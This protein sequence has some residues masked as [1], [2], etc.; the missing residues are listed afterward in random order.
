VTSGG[1]EFMTA[2]EWL[3]QV[4]RRLVMLLRG[5][6]FDADLEEEM[7]LHR[8]LR[9]QEQ[10]ERGLSLQETHYAAQRRFGND[11]LLREESR[12]MWEWNLF[13]NLLRDVRYG[14][15]M[16]ANS[17]AFRTIA[18]LTLAL[19]IGA[20]TAIFSVVNSVLLRPL[21]YHSLLVVTCPAFHDA[22]QSR[23]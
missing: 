8:E 15:R 6:Q 4:G 2:I 5:A 1:A 10:I 21:A 11:L 12:D 14:L 18:V 7:R 3:A 16:L 22:C 23:A 9:K 13:E 19:G 20:N 17:R